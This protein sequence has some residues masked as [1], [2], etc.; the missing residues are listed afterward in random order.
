MDTDI[1]RKRNVGK[2][3]QTLLPGDLLRAIKETI[4]EKKALEGRNLRWL[5]IAAVDRAL[6]T[7]PGISYYF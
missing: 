2:M 1:P 5:K 3:S 6:P 4:S 7:E